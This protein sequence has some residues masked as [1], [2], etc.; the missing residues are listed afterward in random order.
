[1][2]YTLDGQ[3]AFY[4]DDARDNAYAPDGRWMFYID[5]DEYFRDASG[6]VLYCDGKIRP[7]GRRESKKAAIT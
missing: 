4:L 5:N 6:T 1:M 7:R 2:G 3:W